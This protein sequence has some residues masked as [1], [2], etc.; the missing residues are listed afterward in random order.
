MAW[1]PAETHIRP[2][3]S[4]T[5]SLAGIFC[6]GNNLV[7]GR[8]KAVWYN[9]GVCSSWKHWS[10]VSTW[11]CGVVEK[12]VGAR[13]KRKVVRHKIQGAPC[14]YMCLGFSLVAGLGE[15]TW[16]YK[17]ARA[18]EFTRVASLITPSVKVSQVL[19]AR[20][21]SWAYRHSWRPFH[22]ATDQAR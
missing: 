19:S 5:A 12:R 17:D 20:P 13:R 3:L 15:I 10:G 9:S 21:Y 2:K 6:L 8:T 7:G 22:V 1:Y 11:R 16:S 18:L 14:W 4:Y